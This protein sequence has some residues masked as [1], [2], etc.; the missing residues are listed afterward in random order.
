MI[1]KRS[2]LLG[3]DTYLI[4]IEYQLSEICQVFIYGTSVNTSYALHNFRMV[5]IKFYTPN[6]IPHV[7]FDLQNLVFLLFLFR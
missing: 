1:K 2:D 5:R 3:V 4:Q 7:N 6:T